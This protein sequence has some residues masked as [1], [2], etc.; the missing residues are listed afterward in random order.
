MLHVALYGQA[1]VALSSIGQQIQ[2]ALSASVLTDTPADLSIC[3]TCISSEYALW[4]ILMSGGV[5]NSCTYP[6]QKYRVSSPA[7]NQKE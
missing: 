3:S 7:R 6:V 2:L 1:P 4:C 5:Y